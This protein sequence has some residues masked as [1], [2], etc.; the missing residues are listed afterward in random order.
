MKLTPLFVVIALLMPVVAAA[1]PLVLHPEDTLIVASREGGYSLFVRAVPGR[2]SILITESTRDPERREANYALRNPDWHPVN[3]DEPRKLNGEFLN[4][5]EQGRYF[6]ISSTVRNVPGLGAAFEIFIPYVV[7]YGYPWTRSGEFFIGD[8][9]WINIR[10]FELPFA[11]YEGGFADNPF[12]IRMIQPTPA[13]PTPIPTPP[14]AVEPPTE[15]VSE[16]SPDQATD[17]PEEETGHL[18]QAVEA[19]AAIADTT[20]GIA[21]RIDDGEDLIGTVRTLLEETPEGGLDLVFVIDTTASMVGSIA[22]VQ[23][24]L[25]PML[26]EDAARNKPLR[27]GVVLFRDYFDEYL[28]RSLQLQDDLAVVQRYV[29]AARAIGGGDIP[30]AVYEGL[31]MA[32]TRTNWSQDERLVILVGDA[33]PHPRPRGTITRERVVEEAA[34]R[35]VRIH[36]IL[37]PHP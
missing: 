8:D 6:L 1:E 22:H 20:D 31:Y 24:E 21:T 18:E 25:V 7:E 5:Q 32:I 14:P 9:S 15:A 13:E 12:V 4:A 37:L 26:L 11:D 16:P 36:A 35:G 27:V 23:N 3:G 28:T 29:N 19:F 30:E 34:N 2:G 10:T 17:D 33:P